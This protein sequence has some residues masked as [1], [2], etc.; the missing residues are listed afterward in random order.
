MKATGNISLY[1]LRISKF[2][3]F[4]IAVIKDTYVLLHG[5]K[6]ESQ[7]TPSTEI[8]KAIAEAKDY[9]RRHSND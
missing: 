3:I 6:K 7:K 8:D 1:E 9:L 4:F 2:R 5:F